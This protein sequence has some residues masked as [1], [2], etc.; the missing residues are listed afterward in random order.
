[1]V[2]ATLRGFV[3]S[4]D[5]TNFEEVLRAIMKQWKLNDRRLAGEM[6]KQFHRGIIRDMSV[7]TKGCS[8]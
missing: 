7:R 1:M 6:L 4:L 8:A 2:R 3:F 5:Q